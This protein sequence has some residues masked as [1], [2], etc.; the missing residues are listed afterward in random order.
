[1]CSV[2]RN[3]TK[4]SEIKTNSTAQPG[5]ERRP[6]INRGEGGVTLLGKIIQIQVQGEGPNYYSHKNG[7]S[8]YIQR[9]KYGYK[10]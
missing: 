4:S 5:F 10:L 8:K 9:K 2:G 6:F 3:W 1:M 7:G